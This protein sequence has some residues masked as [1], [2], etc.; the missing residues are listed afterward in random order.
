M[1]R[2]GADFPTMNNTKAIIDFTHYADADLLPVAGTI[3]GQMTENAATF[4]SPPVTLAALDGLI[5]TYRTLLA[6]KASRA[7]AATL[8]FQSARRELESALR[9]LGGYVNILAKGDAGTVL[10]SGFP[11]YGLVRPVDYSPPAAPQD[12]RLEQG[13]LS[14]TVI[15]RYRPE[16]ARKG[17]ELQVTTGD[18]NVEA[19]WQTAGF[20]RGMKATLTNLPVAVFVWVRV[21]TAG[22]NGVM[23]AWS[24]PAKIMV[25]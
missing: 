13:A 19:G 16:R 4:P 21:R 14:G 9:D 22:V 1:V 18:P 20:S 2:G 17:N 11:S 15:A 6:A 10:P 12:L 23:G 7:I 3:L 24:D 5:G 8:A 25:A